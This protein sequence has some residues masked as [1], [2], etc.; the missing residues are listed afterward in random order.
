[1]RHTLLLLLLVLLVLSIM[2]LAGRGKDEVKVEVQQFPDGTF[3]FSWPKVGEEYE[4]YLDGALVEI[5]NETKASLNLSSG[6]HEVRVVARIDGRPALEGSVKLNVKGSKPALNF[7]KGCSNSSSFPLE[8]EGR[9]IDLCRFS[10]NGIEWTR[11]HPIEENVS[12]L[13]AERVLAE[14]ISINGERITKT[15]FFEKKGEG[16]CLKREE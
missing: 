3:L 4:V 1:M 7:K 2:I 14:C 11:W 5:T 8:I 6:A 15:L 16:W 13:P 10:V 9:D 12:I